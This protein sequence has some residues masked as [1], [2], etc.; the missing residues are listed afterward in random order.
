MNSQQKKE[1]VIFSFLMGPSMSLVLSAILTFIN[2][3]F[4]F[5]LSKTLNSWYLSIII[6]IPIIL[7]G[8]P[9]IIKAITEEG[10]PPNLKKFSLIM[11]TSFSG[12]ISFI[13]IFL[14]L[15]FGPVFF[16]AWIINWFISFILSMICMVTINPVIR[17]IAKS[18]AGTK[19]EPI[20]NTEMID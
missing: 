1:H 17:S 8:S 3:N 5:N 18:L 20:K 12:I 2:G 9:L 7:F 4:T 6:T 14:N 13:M 15:K 16:I 11:S 10:Q 19:D